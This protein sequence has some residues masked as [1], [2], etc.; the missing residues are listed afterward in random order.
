MVDAYNAVKEA[1]ESDEVAADADIEDAMNQAADVINQMGEIDLASI[2]DQDAYDLN[3]AI[4][5]ILD[6]LSMVVDGMQPADGAEAADAGEGCSDETF[7]ALQDNYATLVDAYNIVSEAYQS[8]EIEADASIEDALNQTADIINEMGSIDQS[9]I[10][11]SD[12]ETLNGTIVDLLDVL[13]A[14]AD[15]M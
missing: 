6:A 1:Y 14:V 9:T 4:G 8:D 3:E 13:G 2:T 7:A 11:E 5:Q 10:D 12:A 15:A